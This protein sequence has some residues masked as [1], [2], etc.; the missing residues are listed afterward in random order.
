MSLAWGSVAEKSTNANFP[1]LV[2]TATQEAHIDEYSS[3][4]NRESIL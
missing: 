1:L 2:V 3:N 4:S